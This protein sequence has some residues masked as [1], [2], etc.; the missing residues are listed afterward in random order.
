MKKIRREPPEGDPQ[1]VLQ[2]FFFYL[3]A[4][5]EAKKSQDSEEQYSFVEFSSGNKGG[6]KFAS[7]YC[8]LSVSS[9]DLGFD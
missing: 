3:D 9:G 5:A 8:F 6:G 2:D 7:I 1:Q 4:F